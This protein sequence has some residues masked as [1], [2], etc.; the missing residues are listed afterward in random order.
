MN[1]LGKLLEAAQFAAR[2]HHGQHRKGATS[3][4]YIVHPLGVARYLTQI[5]KVEDY[6]I[7]IGG[8]LHDTIED[9]ETTAEELTEIFGEKVC[10]YVLE[11]T[12]D[13]DL[14]KNE[15]KQKQIEHAPHLSHGAKQIK[16]ADK[17]SNITDIM[18]NPPTDWTLETKFEYIAWGE[19]VVDGLRGANAELEKY[20]DELI[21]NARTELGAKK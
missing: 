21:A 19:K 3:E 4:P 2:K 6:D 17:I 1:D 5:G 15:R 13:K 16:L 20:F 7:L 18:K 12:D 8:I 9:T 11:V 10:G 14:S